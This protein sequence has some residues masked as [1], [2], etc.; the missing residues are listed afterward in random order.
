MKATLPFALSACLLALPSLVHAE[1]VMSKVLSS[2]GQVTAVF[3][4]GSTQSLKQGD[5]IPVGS[6]IETSGNGVV[7]LGL[8]P[9]A[10]TIVEPNTKATIQKLNVERQGNRVVKR[11]VQLSLDSQEGGLLS[12]LKRSDDQVSFEIRTPT[13]VAA[14]RGT[15]WR[16][17]STSV[18]V[19]NGDVVYTASNGQTIS[20]PGGSQYTDGDETVVDLSDQELTDLIE[21]LEAAGISVTI[22][23]TESGRDIIIND[24]SDN[25]ATFSDV[26]ESP[27]SMDSESEESGTEDP[28]YDPEY[29]LS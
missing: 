5:Y 14:A 25:P 8:L 9:G 2:S 13:G 10:A 12:T 26:E 19:I 7:F 24:G 27:S 29:P 15:T 17:T 3:P 20:I 4:N 23:T 18:Q 21:A 22:S 28:P 1:Q 6:K 16:T 11:D